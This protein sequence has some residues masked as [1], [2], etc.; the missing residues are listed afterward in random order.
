MKQSSRKILKRLLGRPKLDETA[1]AEFFMELQKYSVADLIRICEEIQQAAPPAKPSELET[2]AKRRL[3]EIEG[4]ASDFVPYLLGALSTHLSRD[5]TSLGVSKRPSLAQVVKL[6]E[7][8]A[9]AQAPEMLEAALAAYLE[10][11]D[12]SYALNSA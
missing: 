7:T 11:N 9:P 12:A 10:D 1:L 2:A 5:V 6:V 4:K 3:R 8:L